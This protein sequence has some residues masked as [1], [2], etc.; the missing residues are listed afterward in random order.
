MRFTI[1]G[2][3][4]IGGITGAYLARAGHTVRFV[5]VVEEHVEAINERGLRVS[6]RADFTVRV[7]ATTPEELRPPLGTVIIAV[8]SHHTLEAL[9]GIMP[10]L[11]T[12]ETVVSMQNGLVSREIAGAVGQEAAVAACLSF[13][14]YYAG[15]GHVVHGTAGSLGLGRLDGKVTAELVRLAEALSAVE[16]AYATGDIF[17]CIWA[18]MA[19]GSLYFATA[20]VDAD[21][22]EILDRTEHREVLMDVCAET[23]AVAEAQGVHPVAFAGFDPNA[24]RFGDRDPAAVEASVNG[25]R[26][27]FDNPHQARTGIWLDL[28]VRKRRSEAD[29]H[30]GALLA[31]AGRVGVRVPGNAA[32][33]A[34]VKQLEAGHRTFGWSNLDELRD[35]IAA[36]RV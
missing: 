7:T 33:Y 23:V 35:R 14:G 34:M 18:K 30:L 32:L 10:H 5:D 15:P 26:S 8:K 19:L 4:A 21:V 9:A 24:L 22:Q 2:A 31:E 3:G 16:H 13:G 20:I 17:A 29:A 27:F 12:D 11:A 25:V 6:G 1:V 28:A 36:A